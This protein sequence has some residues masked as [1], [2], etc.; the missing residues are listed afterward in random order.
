MSPLAQALR[1]KT[2]TFIP[3]IVPD[4][5]NPFF[6]E[7]AK[8]MTQAA[9]ERGYQL[10]LCVTN[11]DPAKTDGYFTAMQ[12]HVRPLRHRRALHEGRYR[13][14]E[15]QFDFGHK[16]V[17]IDRVEGDDAV[18]TV[19]VDS[20]RGIMLALGAP[21]LSGAHLDRLRIRHRRNAHRPGPDGRL[22]GA[23]RRERQHTCR[24]GQRVR[25]GCGRRAAPNISSQMD[26]SADGDH[27][28]Q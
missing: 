7:L 4:I 10:L 14:A 24:A 22:S 5:T 17:V 9:D 23:V 3:L 2:S 1:T 26:R 12:A 16:V 15:T 21:A 11:G 27:R 28:G 18:P 13:G 25:P 8:T 6:A 19:T 20:R